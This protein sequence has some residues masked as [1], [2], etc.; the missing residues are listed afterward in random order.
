M[1]DTRDTNEPPLEVVGDPTP[2]DVPVGEAASEPDEEQ[3]SLISPDLAG[4][5][6]IEGGQE[7]GGADT[8]NA[9]DELEGDVER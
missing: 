5:S 2:P 8:V 3:D 9:N 6:L 7:L 1:D 4:D